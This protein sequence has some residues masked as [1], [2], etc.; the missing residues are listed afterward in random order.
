MSFEWLS[1]GEGE[2]YAH[3]KHLSKK[4]EVLSGEMLDLNQ[5]SGKAVKVINE[6]LLSEILKQIL[7]IKGL[8][9]EEVANAVAGIYSDIISIEKSESI[10]IHMIN[11]AI[12]ALKRYRFK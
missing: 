11:A 8:S 9:Q 12:L 3:K 7:K 10:Q 4:R 1:T 2:P 6:K 5:L